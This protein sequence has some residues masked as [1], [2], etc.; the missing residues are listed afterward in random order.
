MPKWVM[1]WTTGTV[2]R[3][4]VF[5]QFCPIHPVSNSVECRKIHCNCERR[6]SRDLL[7]PCALGSWH[8][9]R[10]RPLFSSR[11]SF[12]SDF[13]CNFLGNCAK[14]GVRGGS[15][16]SHTA[17]WWPEC[18]ARQYKDKSPKCRRSPC[19]DPK[20]GSARQQLQSIIDQLPSFDDQLSRRATA[21]RH[22]P[23]RAVFQPGRC[24][25]LNQSLSKDHI[26][27]G[28]YHACP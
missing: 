28:T 24:F 26:E 20:K 11:N 1:L 19:N 10:C 18:G 27:Q 15:C 17:F 5:C 4:C 14:M 3:L 21:F 7:V 22:L 8:V 25:S 6:G 9:G 12:Q 13:G 2:L 23:T 16:S